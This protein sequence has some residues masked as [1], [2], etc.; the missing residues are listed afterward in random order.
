M[1]LDIATVSQ[2]FHRQMER[3]WARHYSTHD[4]AIA[5]NAYQ[6]VVL[7]WVQNGCKEAGGTEWIDRVDLQV[8]TLGI[9]RTETVMIGD[10]FDIIGAGGSARC[11]IGVFGHGVFRTKF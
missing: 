10:E 1:S 11:K 4:V 6:Q 7:H 8:R 9:T 2:S 3:E 5:P